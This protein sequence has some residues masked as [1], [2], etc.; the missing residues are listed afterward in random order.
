[1]KA[2]LLSLLL[3]A[4]IA[5]VAQDAAPP[6]DFSS[7]NRTPKKNV[8]YVQYAAEQQL[9][10]AGKQTVL[11]LRFH[12]VDGFHINSHLPKS[13]LQIPTRIELTPVAGVKLGIPGY[14]AGKAFSFSFAPDEKLD[15][16]QGEFV[17]RLP[18]TASAGAHELDGTLRY[19][20]CDHAACYP[21]KT[22][23]IG[24]VFTAK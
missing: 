22:L 10:P 13:D 23:P 14:P 11:E 7:L 4:S 2:A 17:V 12:V 19:Q 18:V 20:A 15:V 5:A 21:P 8:Q 3:A 24:V 6:Q 9:I 1:M 16:Y